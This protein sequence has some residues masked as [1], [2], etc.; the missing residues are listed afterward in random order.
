[1]SGRMK[2]FFDRLTDLLRIEKDTGRQLRDKYMAVISCSNGGNLEE[3]F[4]LPFKNSAEYL[5]MHYLTDLHT[6]QG[7][8]D[9]DKIAEFKSIIDEKTSTP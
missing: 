6:Y 4:W 2:V 5:G 9:I 1:M 3:Y 8:V 7:D